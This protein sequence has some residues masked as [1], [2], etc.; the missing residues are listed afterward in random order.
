MRPGIVAFGLDKEPERPAEGHSHDAS[1]LQP[2]AS[3]GRRSTR[4]GD[5]ER[6][7][8][9]LQHRGPEGFIRGGMQC[10]HQRSADE[11]LPARSPAPAPELGK[12]WDVGDS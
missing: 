7:P 4:H 12:E 3:A 1:Q 10:E 8:A 2:G 5:C 6:G 11:E 9:P